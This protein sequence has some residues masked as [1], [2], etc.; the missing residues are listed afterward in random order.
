MVLHLANA[1][2]PRR[3]TSDWL[4]RC[5]AD[6]SGGH[7]DH[8]RSTTLHPEEPRVYFVPHPGHIAPKN[9]T[10]PTA[11][12]N[13]DAVGLYDMADRQDF[14]DADRGFIAGLPDGIVLGA[15][16]HVRVRP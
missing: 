10:S 4:W 5:F 1:G 7:V 12:V 2:L 11:Q 6:R 15:D 8:D 16:G 13:R 14:Q 3:R 9:V